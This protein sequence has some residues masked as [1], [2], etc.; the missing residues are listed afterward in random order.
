MRLFVGSHLISTNLIIWVAAWQGQSSNLSIYG[1]LSFSHLVRRKDVWRTAECIE[2]CRINQFPGFS[3]SD[4]RAE[5]ARGTCNLQKQYHFWAVLFNAHPQP[6]SVIRNI[7][8]LHLT[9]I[10]QELNG[11][12]YVYTQGFEFRH[13]Q[14]WDLE[15]QWL[16]QK[17]IPFLFVNLLVY[18]N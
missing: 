3:L 8:F 17:K 7:W 10:G 16:S 9:G 18:W 6:P 4:N 5:R 13:L 12:P 14:T 15:C 11:M 1:W 2:L